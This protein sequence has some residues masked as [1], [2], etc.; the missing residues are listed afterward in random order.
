[1][2]AHPFYQ[3][4]DTWY[5]DAR[6]H[7]GT[8]IPQPSVWANVRQPRFT[9]KIPRV[10]LVTS[11]YFLLGEL[12]RACQ[13]SGFEYEIMELGTETLDQK[14]FMLSLLQKVTS[15]K[16]DCLITMN[17]LA[18]DIEGV[19]VDMLKRMQIP[20]ASWFLD[21]PHLILEGYT[22]AQ[23]PWLALFTWDSDNIASLKAAGHEHVI[24]LPLATDPNRFSPTQ[25]KGPLNKI[26]CRDVTFV[27][28][29]MVYKVA[30]RLEKGR[31]SRPLLRQYKE[32]ARAFGASN[33]RSVRAFLH[34]YDADIAAAFEALQSPEDYLVYEAM[35]TWEATRQ[36]RQ[37]CAKAL[38]PFTPLFVGDH[39]WHIALKHD[40]SWVYHPPVAY[41]DELPRIYPYSTINF[42]CTSKQMKGAVNQRIFD[43]PAAGSFV[44]SDWREQMDALMERDKEIVVYDEIE[45]IPDLIRFYL[46]NTAARKAV[47]KAGR[48]RVLAEHTWAQRIQS[49]VAHM[50]EIYGA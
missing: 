8:S 42:N 43:V 20:M 49:L 47:V 4:F 2:L 9:R 7:V 45:E 1:L 31:F 13:V 36:Y 50:K 27:G 5:S 35:L 12:T 26:V 17:H 18:I 33:E 34:Q 19:M 40:T 25:K 10:L 29:S 37:A 3:R 32:T 22:S 16:P 41:Y 28:N 24:Y 39:G 48:A 38:L 15:Y 46:K 14:E 23:S 30:N 11:K 21:N 6:S 44:L